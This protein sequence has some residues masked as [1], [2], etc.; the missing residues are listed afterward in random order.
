M[1]KH[2]IFKIILALILIITTNTNIY[3]TE[4]S[5]PS[6]VVICEDTNRILYNKNAHQIRPMASLT[7]LMTAIIFV[8]NCK[9]DEII[10]IDKDACYIGG[11]EVGLVPN[12]NITAKDLLLGMLL[13]SGNDAATQIAIHIAGSVENF[14][15]LM[16]IRATELNLNN[17]HFITPHGLDEKNHYTTAYEMALISKVARSY[18][19][20]RDAVQTK[21]ATITI[22]NN[23]RQLK[24]TNA[25]LFDYP[26]AT[27]M[28]TG[29]TDNANRCLS[30]SATKD[31]LNLIAVVLGSESSQIRFN[32]TRNILEETFEKYKYYDLTNFT[33]IYI[34]IPIIKGKEK[35]Y[36]VTY[37]EPLFEALTEDEYKNI[38]IKQE[39]P[40]EITAP[41]KQGDYLGKV[42][43]FTTNDMIIY[44]KNIYL[45]KNIDKMTTKDYTTHIL[46]H[47]FDKLEKI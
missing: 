22:N 1:N 8:E 41:K 38:Y 40:Q 27:G 46:S 13:P 14:S 4:I 47:L 21:Y 32:D 5:S 7:K 37:N 33:N 20:I 23:A 15:K 11:S 25:L 31:N 26:F 24:N 2:N 45:E 12:T 34:N 16:N 44:E 18:K 43:I 3:C 35:E 6:A 19:E 28:K 39:I 9:M 36:I 42:T 17:T 29:Y 10:K 30:A